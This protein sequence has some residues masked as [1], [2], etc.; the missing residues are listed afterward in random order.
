MSLSVGNKP[1][2]S[3]AR[4]T[5]PDARPGTKT[6]ADGAGQAS[7][8][9][10]AQAT[11]G[12]VDMDADVKAQMQELFKEQFGSKAQNAKE[13]HSFMKQVFGEGYDAKKA[14]Q[15]RKMALKDDF[16][17]LPPIE[18]VDSSTLGGAN[19][20]YDAKAGVVYI[21]SDLKNNAQLAAQTYVEEAGH[22]L[23]TKLNKSDTRGD[24]GEM[25]RRVLGGEKLSAAQ[26]REI[27]TENDKGVITVN[28]KQ[29]EV[30]FWNPFKAIGKAI[31]KAV[32]G[33]WNGIKSVGEGIWNGVKSVGEGLWNGVKSFGSG[34]WRATGGFIGNI[35]QGNFGEAFEDLGGGLKEAFFD[36][37]T[38]VVKGALK[39][40]QHVL[41][42]A[43]N[44]FEDVVDGATYLL[45]PLGGPVRAVTTR[46]MDAYR[47]MTVGIYNA[48]VGVVNSAIEGV[49]TMLN[50]AGKVL[51]GDFKEGFKD[52]GMGLLKGTV[53]AAADAVLMVGGKAISAVQT[54]LWLEQPGRRLTADEVAGLREIYGDTIDYDSVRIKEGFAGL[55]SITDNAFTH[56]NTIY[57]KPGDLPL[58]PAGLDDLVAHE[59]AHVWQHQNGGTDYLTEAIWAQEVGDGY[60]Y[61]KA[62]DEGKSWSELS[63]EQQAELIQ[64]AVL[65]AGFDFTDPTDKFRSPANGTDYTAQ[66][67]EAL[68]EIRAGRGAT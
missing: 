54:A 25:F 45:G 39:G 44:A 8:A 51:T 33:V 48:G 35:F 52:M 3:P 16:S 58:D 19:G 23:D 64:D 32:K 26:I 31:G 1:S 6:G 15:Y 10:A 2:F 47:S 40:T 42:G 49:D 27:R 18:F 24:E 61:E 7:S 38:K 68:A 22:H 59:M 17:F 30:E 62:L 21:N 46:V 50:G 60:D 34:L 5:P 9:G 66:L 12:F 41:N 36:A 65:D 29:V 4:H 53:Q 20:A 14:E 13:F 37:P 11:D 57:I 67:Q 56:G 28:G 63:P 43:Y 55:F